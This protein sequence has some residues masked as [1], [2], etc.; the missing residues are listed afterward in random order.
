MNIL[1]GYINVKVGKAFLNQKLGMTVYM[2]LVM[3]MDFATS[4]NLRVKSMMF[5]YC[6]IRKYTWTSSDGKTYI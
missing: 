3:I 2:K 4:K 5:P 6:G 1:V